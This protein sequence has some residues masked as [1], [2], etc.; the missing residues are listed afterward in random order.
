MPLDGSLGGL[1]DQEPQGPF[2]SRGSQASGARSPSAGSLRSAGVHSII[3][4]QASEPQMVIEAM[5]HRLTP[6]R[7]MSGGLPVPGGASNWGR[8]NGRSLQ[9]YTEVSSI[10]DLILLKTKGGL[11]APYAT[12]ERP[13]GMAG[14]DVAD[15]GGCYQSYNFMMGHR[16]KHT[17]TLHGPNERF[18]EAPCPPAMSWEHGWGK[19]SHRPPTH[20]ISTSYIT[21]TQTEIMK[22]TG[23]KATR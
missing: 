14:V 9:R 8:D 1:L 4:R 19:Q 7:E 12:M 2:S 20:P 23:G 18:A 3:R 22:S 17:R 15:K 5:G 13:S 10:K 11:V 6:R 16:V 21:R